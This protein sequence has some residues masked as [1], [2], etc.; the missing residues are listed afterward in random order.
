[1]SDSDEDSEVS[2]DP[3]AGMGERAKEAA[4]EAIEHQKEKLEEQKE[5]E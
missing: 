5:G 3:L 4:D 1:M 2:M